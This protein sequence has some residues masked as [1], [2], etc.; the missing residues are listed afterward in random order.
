MNSGIA[1]QGNSRINKPRLGLGTVLMGSIALLSS[2]AS[3]SVVSV[4]WVGSADYSTIIGAAGELVGPFDS[5]DFSNGGVVLIE[6]ATVSGAGY[7]V[8]DTYNG[9]YQSYVTQHTLSGA[10]A[11]NPKLNN[12]YELTFAAQFTQQVTSVD[13]FGNATFAVTGGSAGLFLDSNVGTQHSFT[14][15][16]GFN[17]GTSILSGTI[18]GGGGSFI[19]SA[20]FGVTGIDLTIGAFDYN[21]AVYDP[22]TIAGA[23]GIFTLNINPYGVSSGV[24]SVMGN[25]VDSTDLLLEADGNLN[26]QAVPLPPALW[27][28]GSVVLGLIGFSRRTAI[29]APSSIGPTFITA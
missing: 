18:S 2:T 4:P 22:A 15:D 17:D 24:S 10:P 26:L 28:L 27:L 20:G 7:Q 19:S 9:Y 29:T 25:T 14:T 3:A 12:S 23:N 1:M 16:S 13:G 21:T 8:G 5:Y 11:A 6:P